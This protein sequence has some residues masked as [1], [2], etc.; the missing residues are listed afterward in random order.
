MYEPGVWDE[1]D[2]DLE[3]ELDNGI[4]PTIMI[5]GPFGCTRIYHMM[6]CELEDK[7]HGQCAICNLSNGLISLYTLCNKVGITFRNTQPV[8]HSCDNSA[9]ARGF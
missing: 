6:E 7:V 1:V 8:M 5:A 3:S 4:R 9:G 2:W